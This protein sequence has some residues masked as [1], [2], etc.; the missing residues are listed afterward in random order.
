[1]KIGLAI[2]KKNKTWEYKEIVVSRTQAFI[3]TK[4]EIIE[5]LG[6]HKTGIPKG[7]YDI[8]RIPTKK[9]LFIDKINQAKGYK[10]LSDVCGD[11]IKNII[12]E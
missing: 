3:L 6:W 4:G 1:V 5:K 8:I 9:Q 12:K 2:I 11:I 7:V 10:E